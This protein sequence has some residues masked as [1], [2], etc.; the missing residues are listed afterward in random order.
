MN[1]HVQIHYEKLGLARTL[2]HIFKERILSFPHSRIALRNLLFGHFALFLCVCVPWVTIHFD[3]DSFSHCSV[4]SILNSTFSY[5]YS[6]PS[7]TLS[8][9]FV[10]PSLKKKWYSA[11][12][13]LCLWRCWKYSLFSFPIWLFHILHLW[14]CWI[15]NIWFWMSQNF[16]PLFKSPLIPIRYFFCI[17][18]ILNWICIPIFWIFITTYTFWISIPS[19]FISSF[20]IFITTYCIFIPTY[21]YSHILILNIYYNILYSTFWIFLTTYCIQH[22]AYLFHTHFGSS[23][24]LL[25][26]YNSSWLFRIFIKICIDFGIRIKVESYSILRLFC[27]I[28]R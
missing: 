2:A 20:W 6:Y 19:T 14:R 11:W 13:H 21:I 7:L 3:F 17:Y 10:F 15:S 27:L 5:S 12:L 25:K 4:S 1:L 24:C 26:V 28:F 18:L 8:V 22:F 16:P 23:K 9:S